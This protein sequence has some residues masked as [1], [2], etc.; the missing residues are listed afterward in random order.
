MKILLNILGIFTF[1]LIRFFNRKDK[2]TE[3]S[4]KFWFKDNKWES[5]LI[6][7]VDFQLMIFAL[8]GG[9]SVDL[10]KVLPFLPDG[11]N[12]TGDWALC[13]MMGWFVAWLVYVAIKKKV[14]DTNGK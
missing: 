1:F 3:P 6:L 5:F 11:I 10:E 14:E 9:L 4:F 2:V 13:A 8:K 12:L 7:L